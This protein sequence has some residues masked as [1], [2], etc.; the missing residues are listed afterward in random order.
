MF[1]IMR[2]LRIIFVAISLSSFDGQASFVL[3]DDFPETLHQQVASLAQFEGKPYSPEESTSMKEI[4]SALLTITAPHIEESAGYRMPFI[5]NCSVFFF[6]QIEK[7]ICDLEFEEVYEST[8]T[9]EAE[10]QFPTGYLGP[11]RKNH[12]LQTRTLYYY[13]VDIGSTI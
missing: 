4:M 6:T 11:L 5:V 1:L 3:Q 7:I 10:R 13:I 2:F 8:A 12:I 9:C